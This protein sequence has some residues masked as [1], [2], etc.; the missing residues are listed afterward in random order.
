MH[1]FEQHFAGSRFMIMNGAQ[2]F[3]EIFSLLKSTTT[4][5]QDAKAPETISRSYE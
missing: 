4:Q 3:L 1:I 5:A 2:V